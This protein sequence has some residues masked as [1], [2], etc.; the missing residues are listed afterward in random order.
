MVI[1]L[2][3]WLGRAGP[4]DFEKREGMVKTRATRVPKG[5]WE[6]GDVFSRVLREERAW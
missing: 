2:A 6:R 3:R 1:C 4:A 5:S